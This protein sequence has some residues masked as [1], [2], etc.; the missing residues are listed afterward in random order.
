[1][2]NNSNQNDRR[3]ILKGGAAALT[4]LGLSPAI[5]LGFLPAKANAS[6]LLE[7]ETRK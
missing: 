6:Q 7:K 5:P 1:M 4:A 2:T 3:R